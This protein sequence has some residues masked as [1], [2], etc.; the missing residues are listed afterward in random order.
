MTVI[1]KASLIYEPK[2]LATCSGTGLYAVM[3]ESLNFALRFF[4]YVEVYRY[5]HSAAVPPEQGER[6]FIPGTWTLE[7][8][9]TAQLQATPRGIH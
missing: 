2:R 8:G 4:D 5:S 1:F 9:P 7:A 6:I 3:P